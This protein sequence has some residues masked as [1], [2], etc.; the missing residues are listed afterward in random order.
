MKSNKILTLLKHKL[1]NLKIIP[2]RMIQIFFETD[3]LDIFEDIFQYII[4]NQSIVIQINS[5][6]HYTPELSTHS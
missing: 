4:F 1:F 2:E 5:S 6:E 3:D